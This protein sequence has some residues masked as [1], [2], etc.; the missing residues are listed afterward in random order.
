M[1]GHSKWSQIKR[2]KGIKDQQKGQLFSKI[3]RLITLA[4]KEGGRITNPEKNVKLRLAIEKA[5]ES[6]MPKENIKRA[7][8]RAIKEGG[9]GMK[10]V[11]YEI[12]APG[13]GSLLVSATTDNPKRT[14][15]DIKK[16]LDKEG[17]KI[18]S[19]GSTSFLFQRV[20]LIVFDKKRVSEEQ[21]LEF[22]E[23]IGAF[24]FDENE[25]NYSFFIPFEKIGKVNDF[26]SG[27]EYKTLEIDY[28]P[29]STINVEDKLIAQKIIKIIEALESL[30]DVQKVSTNFTI[31]DEFL[32]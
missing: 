26:L 11:V 20:G 1:S 13:G 23:K 22:A 29:L 7:I 2:K 21:V 30:E 27:L 32:K 10:E 28:R 24:D 6:N 4:V 15:Y 18:S 16:V 31:P 25:E 3:S 17:G 8:E 12:F 9:E 14:L 19:A 5:K